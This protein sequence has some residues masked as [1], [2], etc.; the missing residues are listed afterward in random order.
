MN[1]ADK[2][3]DTVAD[4]LTNAY[5]TR[6]EEK[7]ARMAGLVRGHFQTVTQPK[8]QIKPHLP[9]LDHYREHL[10]QS[11]ETYYHYIQNWQTVIDCVLDG[12]AH[13]QRRGPWEQWGEMITLALKAAC[14]LEN[15]QTEAQLLYRLGRLRY[16]QGLIYDAEDCWQQA[17]K[18]Y[19]SLDDD[20]WVPR[21]WRWLAEQKIATGELKTAAVYAKKALAA[22]QQNGDEVGLA[23]TYGTLGYVAMENNDNAA[24]LSRYEQAL[25][26][27]A[28]ATERDVLA[29][30]HV[31][32]GRLHIY[33]NA[34]NKALNHYHASRTL[35]EADGDDDLLC[36]VLS[37]MG[38]I[39]GMRGELQ[40]SLEAFQQ[41][42]IVAERCGNMRMVLMARSNISVSH[43]RLGQFEESLES[44]RIGVRVA[45]ELGDRVNS[46]VVLVNESETLCQ[47]GRVEEAAKSVAEVEAIIPTIDYNIYYTTILLG[48]QAS[49]ARL[50]GDTATALDKFAQ[51][52]ALMEE[53][54]NQ[55]E[56]ADAAIE[57]VNTYLAMSSDPPTDVEQ[58]VT[59]WIE[60]IHH[61]GETLEQY[62]LISEGH[63]LAGQIALL[64]GDHETARRS[65]EAAKD[66]LLTEE[67]DRNQYLLRVLERI[68]PLLNI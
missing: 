36:S 19:A 32:I 63:R 28:L 7:A 41:M 55:F 58:H 42:R 44:A 40:N 31:R 30:T 52:S 48:A 21:I 34:Y 5:R 61:A 26:M 17:E 66:A 54:G 29:R 50:Q 20:V 23:S 46:M 16:R 49:V 59:P 68:S 22:Q 53:M 1:A 65:Y 3:T 12:D 56:A 4:K 2:V 62:D 45:K 38:I 13:M 67:N 35:A 25:A 47:L 9:T 15:R 60:K 51:T 24:A 14:H 33:S 43:Y 27:P 11:V 6:F 57:V 18:L 64:Q 37:G 8:K 10:C 39:Y